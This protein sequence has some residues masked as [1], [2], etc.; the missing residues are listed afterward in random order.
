MPI[1]GCTNPP[2]VIVTAEP[3]ELGPDKKGRKLHTT[4]NA[5]KTIN[6]LVEV[7]HF[8]S[9]LL[10]DTAACRSRKNKY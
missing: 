10:R 8:I 4:M 5:A 1:V 7:A 6:E 9:L 2:A 3:K